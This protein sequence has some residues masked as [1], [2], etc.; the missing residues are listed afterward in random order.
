[1]PGARSIRAGE[2]YVELYGDDSR[3]TRTLRNTQRKLRRFGQTSRRIGAGTFAAVGASLGP[4]AAISIR[5]ASDANEI[6]NRFRAVFR[7]Q[8]EEAGAFADELGDAVGRSGTKLRGSLSDFMGFFVGMGFGRDQASKLSQEMTRLALDFGS[9]NNLSDAEANQRFISALSGS[10]EVVD[11]FGINLKAAALGLELQRLGLAENTQSA[12][13]AEKAIARY[14]IIY[15]SLSDQGAVGDAIRTAFEFANMQRR[16]ADELFDLS[17]AIGKALVPSATK[18]LAVV[19]GTVDA[20][21]EFVK[22]NGDMVLGVAKLG[23]VVAIA[24]GSVFALGVAAT[25]LAN[26]IGLA[27]AGAA[28]LVI[29]LGGIGEATGLFRFLAVAFSDVAKAAGM[30]A[31]AI[32]EAFAGGRLDKA[33]DALGAG[34]ALSLI[35]AIDTATSYLA[36]AIPGFAGID[37]AVDGVEALFQARLDTI[38]AELGLNPDG[39][40]GTVTD[41]LPEWLQNLIDSLSGGAGAAPSIGGLRGSGVLNRLAG[42]GPERVT[43]DVRTIAR[44]TAEIAR[45]A[46]ELGRYS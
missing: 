17:D 28:G 1:M 15:R 45:A 31:Q 44:Q 37:Q 11:R 10:S 43:K 34:L 41:G 21:T 4:I 36:M 18:A 19:S 46:Q 6:R 2:A 8:A 9:F 32:I 25:V 39:S 13:E 40:G 3:L 38:R 5:A 23:A 16:A 7:E 35:E 14:S 30:A 20:M 12:T 26:P 27:T 22:Q 42:A 33:W 24:A 29:A